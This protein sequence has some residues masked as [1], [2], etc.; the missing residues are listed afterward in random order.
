MTQPAP[1]SAAQPASSKRGSPVWVWVVGI[2]IAFL[3]VFLGFG[4]LTMT[5]EKAAFYDKERAIKEA[6]SN[7]TADSAPGTERRMTREMCNQMKDQL[8]AER[9]RLR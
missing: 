9:A 1:D 6:C 3:V 2:P 8:E 4:A 7:L 5:P